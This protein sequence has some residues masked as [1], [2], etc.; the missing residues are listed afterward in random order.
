MS[1]GEGFD[2][3]FFESNADAVIDWTSRKEELWNEGQY[4]FKKE[5]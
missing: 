3:R 2:L 4:T 1:H 5:F